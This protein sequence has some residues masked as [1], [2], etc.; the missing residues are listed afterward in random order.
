[1]PVDAVG[2]QTV[3]FFPD[4]EG[5]LSIAIRNAFDLD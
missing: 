5:A 1:V 3:F 4:Q 2:R